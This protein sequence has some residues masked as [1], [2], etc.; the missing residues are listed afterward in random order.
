MNAIITKT[1]MPPSF[2]EKK[3]LRYAGCKAADE[4]TIKL[5]RSCIAEAEDKLT[6]SI[7]YGEFPLSINDGRCDFGVFSVQSSYLAKNLA[8]CDSVLIFA[9]TVGVGI[10]RLIAKYGRISPTRSVMMDALGRERVE[11]LCDEF[12]KDFALENNV[13]LKPRFSPGFGDLSL[14][15]QRDIFAVLDC[16]RKIGLSL[17]DSLLMSPAKSVTA[18]VGIVIKSSQSEVDGIAGQNSQ[19]E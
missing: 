2:S 17:N 11:A 4:E 18:F 5:L 8:A 13:S 3:A 16:P 15:T 9:A 12:C 1:Y 7:C 19:S 6:Y 14:S 10:D